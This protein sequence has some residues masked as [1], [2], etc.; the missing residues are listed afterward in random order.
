MNGI[1]SEPKR[2]THLLLPPDFPADKEL[3]TFGNDTAASQ[4]PGEWG[5]GGAGRPGGVGG[6]AKHF[7]MKALQLNKPGSVLASADGRNDPG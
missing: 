6:S 3:P 2:S 5:S 1:W 4:R 7:P